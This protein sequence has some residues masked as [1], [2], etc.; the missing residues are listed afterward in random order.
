MALRLDRTPASFTIS[1]LPPPLTLFLTD[2][3]AS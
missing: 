2:P 1:Q 3:L